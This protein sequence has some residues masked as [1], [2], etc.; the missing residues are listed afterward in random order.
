MLHSPRAPVNYSTNEY[1]I[2]RFQL[3]LSA[4]HVETEGAHFIIT[5]PDTLEDVASL[6][7]AL[8]PHHKCRSPAWFYTFAGVSATSR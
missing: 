1:G 2:S 5:F 4:F 6:F 8:H 7:A 3:V